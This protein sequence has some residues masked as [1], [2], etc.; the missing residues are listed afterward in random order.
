[1]GGRGEGGVGGFGEGGLGGLGGVGGG[2]HAG[3]ELG[4]TTELQGTGTGPQMPELLVRMRLVSWL[5]VPGVPAA[6][7]EGMVPVRRL[8]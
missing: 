3:R 4:S 2:E 8:E 1:M 5:M 7:A 6:Q